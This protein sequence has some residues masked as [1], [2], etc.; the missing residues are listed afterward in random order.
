MKIKGERGMGAPWLGTPPP[1]ASKNTSP[2]FPLTP[3]GIVLTTTHHTIN[4]FN[5]HWNGIVSDSLG[6]Y[7]I[8]DNGSVHQG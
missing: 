5:M 8:L 7:Q 6:W 3:T 4:R 1:P 2:P